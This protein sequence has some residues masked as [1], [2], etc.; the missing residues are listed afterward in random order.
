LVTVQVETS[1]SES[2]E[3]R[4]THHSVV[5]SLPPPELPTAYRFTINA[6]PYHVGEL[7]QVWI[8]LEDLSFYSVESQPRK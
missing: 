3:G 2:V 4:E 5:H 6:R 1:E 7:L 8:D